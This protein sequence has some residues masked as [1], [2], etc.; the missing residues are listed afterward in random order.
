[1]NIQ[2]IIKKFMELVSS[3]ILLYNPEDT[4]TSIQ[5][6]LNMIDEITK[7]GC[8]NN[9][10][11]VSDEK[12]TLLDYIVMCDSRGCGSSRINNKVILLLEEAIK[13]AGG[14]TRDELRINGRT[15]FLQGLED[16][17]SNTEDSFLLE[18]DRRIRPIEE[19]FDRISEIAMES[20][21]LEDEYISRINGRTEF[22]QDL[23]RVDIYF[24]Q[25]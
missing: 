17:Q 1:M 24:T 15:E 6:A 11:Y 18:F 16:R 12:F 5:T 9:E 21:A 19:I 14:K 8:I 22:L 7:N 13:N 20:Q 23:G 10:I 2:E 25:R 4:E 3:D